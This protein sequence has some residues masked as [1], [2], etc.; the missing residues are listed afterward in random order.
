MRGSFPLFSF[1]SPLPLLFRLPM[2]AGH[3]HLEAQEA[4]EIAM[5]QRLAAPWDPTSK[6]LDRLST[7]HLHISSNASLTVAFRVGLPVSANEQSA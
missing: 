3:D 2:G 4:V 1:R 6:E 7:I 5:L